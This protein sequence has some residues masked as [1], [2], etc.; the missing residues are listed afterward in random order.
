LLEAHVRLHPDKTVFAAEELNF[1]GFHV[2]VQGGVSPA[3]VEYQVGQAI[4]EPTNIRLL[5][6][7]SG[8]VGFYS[9][10]ILHFADI[11]ELLYEL[12]GTGV[13]MKLVAA[14]CK[15]ICVFET[16]FNF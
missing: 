15:C 12:L 1:A 3:S 11:A 7:F 2:N 4:T 16:G 10:F 14:V 6:L 5:R 9:K 13:P 8:N